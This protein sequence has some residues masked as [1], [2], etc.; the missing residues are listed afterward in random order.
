[1]SQPAVELAARSLSPRDVVGTALS[2]LRRRSRRVFGA[3]VVVF[4][5]GA[6]LEVP[7][8]ILLDGGNDDH[9]VLIALEVVATSF[10]AFG[11]TFFAG[12]IDRTVGEE[13]RGESPQ[14]MGE[15]VRNL[16][17]GR[18]IIADILFTIGAAFFM[19]LLVIPGIVFYT[20]YVFV[21][22]MIIMED[23]RVIDAFRRS[24]RIVRRHFF[25]VLMLVT[26]PVLVEES[27]VHAFEVTTEESI[28]VSTVANVVLGVIV[29]S[30]VGLIEVTLAYRLAARHPA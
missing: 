28:V 19:I 10:S 1:V 20:F 6:L 16:P 30:V 5:I 18:L 24:R 11:L 29:V 4:G 21:G 27:I 9:P 12:L 7:V 26:V 15:I 22:P 8:L 23:R 3:G 17:Y 14:R 25:L 13:E 2:I